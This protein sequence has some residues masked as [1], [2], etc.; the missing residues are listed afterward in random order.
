MMKKLLFISLLFS[1][2]SCQSIEEQL[3]Q[4]EIDNY[5]LALKG[6]DL[7]EIAVEA[8]LVAELYKQ[9]GDEENY[10]KWKAISKEA[11]KNAG[12]DF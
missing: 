3:I 2:I 11:D 1:A 9:A 6:G 10:L 12:L 8:G 4:D 5:N 7:I